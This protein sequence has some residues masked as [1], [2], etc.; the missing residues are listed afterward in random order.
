MTNRET[1]FD[2]AGFIAQTASPMRMDAPIVTVADTAE[3][4]AVFLLEPTG[5][6]AV[7][8]VPVCEIHFNSSRRSLAVCHLSSG[9]FARHFLT[10][11]SSAGGVIG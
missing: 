3:V 2:A 7:T 4:S 8:G 5:L 11:R 9:S 10:T 1:G 6:S